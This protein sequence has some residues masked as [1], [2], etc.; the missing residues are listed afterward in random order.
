MLFF[1]NY[2]FSLQSDEVTVIRKC[3][4]RMRHKEGDLIEPRDCVLLKAGPRKND[5]PF[6]AKV[7]ALWESPE[8]GKLSLVQHFVY[9]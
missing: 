7:A 3:Y 9:L 6:V 4:P 5:L 1:Y 2:Y 8:D